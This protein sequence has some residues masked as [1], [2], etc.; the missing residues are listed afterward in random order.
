LALALKKVEPVAQ[1]LNS[2]AR[3]TTYPYNLFM[4]AMEKDLLNR[5]TVDPNVLVGK[6]TIR[7]LRISVEQ[8]LRALAAGVPAEDLLVDYP[9]LE[10]EDIRAALAYA[11]E[12]V[13]E[14]HVFP[15]STGR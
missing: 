14:E 15:I 4:R 8:I 3:S 1:G 7:G 5:I 10:L 9:E 2:F 6:P 11:A 13:A 12:L